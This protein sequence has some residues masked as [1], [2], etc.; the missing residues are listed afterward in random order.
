M[1]NNP[2]PILIPYEPD[3]FWEGIRKIVRDELSK[4]DLSKPANSSDSEVLGFASKPLYKIS[5]ICNLFGITE[6]TVR[7]WVKNGILKQIKIQSR[8]YF[9][10]DDVQSLLKS[11]MK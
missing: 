4:L 1:H 11:G 3:V 8:V 5:E 6:P 7:E 9:L 2:L 10:H